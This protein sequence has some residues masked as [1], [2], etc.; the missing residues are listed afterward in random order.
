MV[1]L[2]W[3]NGMSAVRRVLYGVWMLVLIGLIGSALWGWP[4][5]PFLIVNF[6]CLLVLAVLTFRDWNHPPGERTSAKRRV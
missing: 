5:Y 3:W 2:K 4:I 1:V 6:V